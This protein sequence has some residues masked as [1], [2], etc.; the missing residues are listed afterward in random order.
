LEQAK[1]LDFSGRRVAVAGLGISGYWTAR[2]LSGQGASVTLSDIRPRRELDADLCRSLEKEGV[3]LET[4]GH[5]I[6]SFVEAHAV[7]VSPGVPL[8]AEPLRR[9]RHRG[10]AVMGE[11][12]LASR[13]IDT[14]IVAVTGTN[15]KSTVTA[16]LGMI[17]ERA[18]REVFVG[19][20][21]GTPLMAY[22]AG[23]RR[24]DFVVVEVSSFQLDTIE[25]FSPLLAVLLNISPD[26]LERYADY[27]AYVESKLRIC[28]NQGAGQSLVIN[29]DDERLSL[30]PLPDRVSVLRCGLEAR[31]GRQAYL[32]S[33]S[34]VAGLEGEKSHTFSL[35]SFALP[36]RHNLQNLLCTVL[37]AMALRVEP[38]VIQA[39]IDGFKGLPHR[40]ERLGDV[41]GVAFY[42]DSKATNVES[43]VE[44]LRSMECPV[45]LIAGGRHKGSD[46]APLVKAAE[47]RVR[48][49]VF[50]GEAAERLAGAFEGLMPYTVAD[51]LEEAVSVAFSKSEQGDVVLLA[52][53]CSSFDMFRD[54]VHRGEV[55]RHSVE[56]LADDR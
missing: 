9:A 52:P 25:T 1:K 6:S 21:I 8:D 34:L 22:A 56:R 48:C 19:G 55:F 53:A 14:P 5:R 18:G 24:T 41:G 10:V 38:P 16:L 42:N 51:S 43:A 46:Y 20:N 28:M 29:D 54:F 36:G 33:G 39:S 27:E 4:G 17:L 13:L 11:L 23:K 30:E 44:A 37:A 40:L 2:W 45:V 50:L 35:D 7:V 26:H 12:E 3:R 49:G 47:G 31:D 15:G 32:R